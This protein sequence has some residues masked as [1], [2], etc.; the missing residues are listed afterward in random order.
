MTRRTFFGGALALPPEVAQQRDMRAGI[1]VIWY[2]REPN[3]EALLSQPY[4]KGGQI[5][6]QWAGVEPER[7]KYDFSPIDR[8]LAEISRRRWFTTIQING[9]QKPGW[10]FDA[11]PHLPE[12]LSIQISDRQGTLMYW[13]PNHRDAYLNMLDA[14]SRYVK[15]SRYGNSI[16][17]LRMNLNAIGTEHL[18]VPAEYASPDK[19]KVPAGVAPETIE[20]WTPKVAASYVRAVVDAYVARFR[21]LIRIFVRNS[22]HEEIAA[23][24]RGLFDDGTLSWFHTSSEAEPRS[25]GVEIQYKRFYESCRSGRTTCYAEPWASAWGHHGGIRDDRWCSPP[26]W[27][28]WRLL[29][30]LHCGVSYIALYASDLRMAVEGVYR[31]GDVDYRDTGSYQPEFQEAIRFADRYAGYHAM[32]EASPGAWVAFRENTVVRAANRMPAERRKLEFQKS[33]YNFLMERVEPD[34]TQ[35][36]DVVNVGPPEQRFGAW[37]RILPPGGTMRFRLNEPFAASLTGVKAQVNVV[38]LDEKAGSFE[39]QAG[40]ERRS[41]RLQGSGR[42]QTAQFPFPGGNQL[43]IRGG[44]APVRFHML[45][46]VRG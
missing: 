34:K 43:H 27:F 8:E 10:L 15:S 2:G 41:R 12:K 5:V 35:G 4:L 44:G 23:G 7:G 31:S 19:W 28:Y 26:Q 11:V 39:V 37:A 36:L 42:W 21:G 32:P 3:Q 9:N 22:I 16:L 40:A 18:T 24:Y 46:I 30:D 1:Y 29:S 6:L 20:P 38:Y 45:E 17:G 33:D 14:F 25:S 13:H